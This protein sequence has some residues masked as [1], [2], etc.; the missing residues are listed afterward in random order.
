M[1]A[2]QLR[3]REQRSDVAITV[4]LRRLLHCVRNDAVTNVPEALALTLRERR[5][6]HRNSR[7]GKSPVNVA[8][9]RA[10]TAQKARP[11]LRPAVGAKVS[12]DSLVKREARA[13]LLVRQGRLSERCPRNGKQAVFDIAATGERAKR[14]W[15]GVE[16]PSV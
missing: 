16:I 15:E 13:L 9:Y 10:L 14:L 8:L 7:H 4:L 12:L 2:W 3:H 1:S 5:K 6:E 11:R